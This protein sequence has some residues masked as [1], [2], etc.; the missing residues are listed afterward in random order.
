MEA[1]ADHDRYLMPWVMT[2][3][4]SSAALMTLDFIS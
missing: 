3:A 2:A 1:R 4:I